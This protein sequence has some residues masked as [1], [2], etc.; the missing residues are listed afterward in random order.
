LTTVHLVRTRW[1]HWGAHSGINQFIK[2]VDP[3]RVAIREQHVVDGNRNWQ[4]INRT[5][6]PILRRLTSDYYKL[7]DL[8]GEVV[9]LRS[10]LA[11][12]SDVLHFL[13]ADTSAQLL[14]RL[15]VVR[16]RTCTLASYHQPPDILRRVITRSLVTQ[17]DR[18]IVVSSDQAEFFKSYGIDPGRIEVILHGIDTDFF[19][20]A[21][22][23]LGR[24]TFRCLTVG[25][26]L[27]DFDLLERIARRLGGA[28]VEF[29][30][31][32]P[33][34]G[35]L[36]GLS[37]VVWHR[38]VSDDV[39]QRLYQEADVLLLPL[40]ASTANNALLEGLAS[41][42][43]VLTTRL[44]SVLEYLG[45]A[46]AVLAAPGDEEPL[47]ES[48]LELRTDAELRQRMGHSSRRR[49]EELDWRRVASQ[50]ER[51]YLSLTR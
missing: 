2:Y 45:G 22:R 50:Y 38:G 11:S 4:R 33:E 7:T 21:G 14:P 13:D 1:A 12:K 43:P 48:I 39:L 37:H 36:A 44:P 46:E 6:S 27:R 49:A 30:V 8:V 41:G 29:H 20:P 47:I 16:R 34:I 31:V 17:F 28:S 40:T 51:L 23:D 32:S 25:F 10:I 5:A 19:R 26:W 35:N 42:L 9:A 18:V 3:S 24:R 15:G